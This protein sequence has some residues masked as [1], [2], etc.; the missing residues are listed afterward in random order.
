M[1]QEQPKCPMLLTLLPRNPFEADRRELIYDAGNA[2][3]NR[4]GKDW[5]KKHEL[6]INLLRW[7][8][9]DAKAAYQ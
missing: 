2:P 3:H 7:F 4:T 5:I 1:T 8:V 9:D 6:A